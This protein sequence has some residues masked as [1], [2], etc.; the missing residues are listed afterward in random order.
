MNTKTQTQ[1]TNHTPQQIGY[2]L[3]YRPKGYETLDA[4]AKATGIQ[5]ADLSRNTPT[6]IQQYIQQQQTEL[7]Q[8]HQTLQ[9]QNKQLQ[10]QLQNIQQQNKQQ[11]DQ[12]QT[13]QQQ[14]QQQL[15][16]TQQQNKQLQQQL[17]E[18]QQQNNLWQK[19]SAIDNNIKPTIQ[20]LTNISILTMLTIVAIITIAINTHTIANV[21]QQILPTPL[22]TMMAIVVGIAPTIFAAQKQQ[23][24][25]YTMLVFMLID[26]ALASIKNYDTHIYQNEWLTIKRIAMTYFAAQF[27]ITIQMGTSIWFPKNNNIK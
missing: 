1:E 16:E 22:P 10:Q 17:T 2:Y 18:T 7:Q 5:K 20:Q 4:I 27:A 25:F 9:Q 24:S 21:F 26:L 13:D 8:Q 6:Y 15:T 14:L 19:I 23:H 3:L 11:T 12:Q